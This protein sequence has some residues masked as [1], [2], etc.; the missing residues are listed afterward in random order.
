MLPA[1][2]GDFTG[3]EAA[4]RR[5]LGVIRSSTRGRSAA[6]VLVLSGH[7]GVG[8]SALALH[9]AHR[10]ADRFPDGCFYAS[11]GS[12]PAA[13]DRALERFLR[14]LGTPPQL[15]PES[16]DERHAAFHERIAGRSVLIVV[17]DA[18]VESQLLP[19]VPPGPGER[20]DR[21]E[22]AA[23]D[24]PPGR[25]PL[26]GR[27]VRPC[28]V[29]G[30]AGTHPRVRT[31][32][33]RSRGR[34]HPRA[35]LRAPAARGAD[36]GG[37]AR[38]PSAL[39]VAR[40]VLAP[41]RRLDT[42]GRTPARGHGGAGESAPDLRVAGPRGPPTA[43]AAGAARHSPHRRVGVRGAP[44][45]R[46]TY[47]GEASRRA[48]G[49]APA[50]DRRGRLGRSPVRSV[51]AARAGPVVRP[52]TR[53]GRGDA[54]RS[55]R[56]HHPGRAGVPAAGRADPCPRVRRGSAAAERWAAGR[57]AAAGGGPPRR[58]P[59]AGRATRLVAA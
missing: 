43:A 27:S 22:Q 10:T 15:I 55:G 56:G 38:R 39:D 14:A 45:L 16:S 5:M 48:R 24:R 50:R 9:L 28:R 40:H 32:R 21:H 46:R 2:V 35:V 13:T 49:A 58:R 59:T 12:D 54:V 33:G 51:P 8:K 34:P 20:A 1:G 29:D 31:H 53:D 47:G 30:A 7:G 17:D 18:T 3:R 11:I 23:T 42:A 37:P 19:L 57:R 41:G 44:E 52:R 36:R 6:A 4:I 25:H 26:R